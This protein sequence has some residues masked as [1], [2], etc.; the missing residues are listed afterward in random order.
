MQEVTSKRVGLVYQ[1]VAWEVGLKKDP[2][3][4]ADIVQM[5]GFDEIEV[6]VNVIPY[7]EAMCKEL[8][9]LLKEYDIVVPDSALQEML[10]GKGSQD[11]LAEMN[12][13][14]DDKRIPD[15][16]KMRIIVSL[17]KVVHNE[18]I[19]RNSAMFFNTRNSDLKCRFMA[20]ELV[21]YFN[22]M[23]Y[24][25][26]YVSGFVRFLK[27]QIDPSMM[28]IIYRRRQDKLMNKYELDSPEKLLEFVQN[29]DG[30]TLPKEVAGALEGKSG[31]A[32]ARQMIL[33]LA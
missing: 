3:E 25:W 18:W 12:R 5:G 20:F 30:C 26:P 31:E 22:V 28:V 23:N 4:M 24:V 29:G 33:H 2:K 6:F 16:D 32:L 15:F 9:R 17:M 11:T 14:I 10:H 19:W 7:I 27:W 1:N 21:G 13:Q 8:S